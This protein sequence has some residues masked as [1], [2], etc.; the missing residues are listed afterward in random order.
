MNALIAKVRLF[1]FHAKG[2]VTTYV[3]LAIAGAGEARNQWPDLI[4]ALP[5]WHWLVSLEGHTF[6]ILGLLVV[7]TRVRRLLQG[8]T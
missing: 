5:Q 7:Y 3:G 4:A 1:I 2:K 6:F 8:T